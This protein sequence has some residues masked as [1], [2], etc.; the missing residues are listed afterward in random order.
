MTKTIDLYKQ[1]Y[2]YP[3]TMFEPF[4]YRVGMFLSTRVKE[5]PDE[6]F[7]LGCYLAMQQRFGNVAIDTNRLIG[8]SFHQWPGMSVDLALLKT[9]PLLQVEITSVHIGAFISAGVLRQ[10][11]KVAI[12][13]E[14][15]SIIDDTPLVLY[16]EWIY[17]LRYWR[18]ETDIVDYFKR[19]MIFRPVIS[20]I[21][22]EQIDILS[23]DTVDWQQLAVRKA[24]SYPVTIITGG[25]GT[26]KTYTI[27]SVL[28]VLLKNQPFTK[29]ALCAPTGK[30]ASRMM[31]SIENSLSV[32][33]D[34]I[35][36][37]PKE[38]ITIHRL[39][40]WNP[41][42]GKPKYHAG[43]KLPYD[44]VILDEASM[45]D[46]ALLSRLVVAIPEQ[47]RLILLGDKDQ[48]ASVEAGS[49]FGEIASIDQESVDD[50]EFKTEQLRYEDIF[51]RL[52]VSRR[53]SSESGIGLLAEMVNRSDADSSWTWLKEQNS[54]TDCH[55]GNSDTWMRELTSKV[56]KMHDR[57]IGEIADLQEILSLDTPLTQEMG[58]K[59]NALFKTLTESQILS[60]HRRGV[61]GS[62][63]F[64]KIIDAILS[65]KRGLKG[66]YPKNK[67]EGWYH[68]RPVIVTANDYELGL[69][70]G[71]VGLAIVI[72]DQIKITFGYDAITNTIR[73]YSPAQLTNVDTSWIL[74]V[75]KSQGSE[76]DNVDLILPD[77][78]SPILTRELA[79]TALTRSK[80]SF[81][82]WGTEKVWKEMINC[83]IER[84]SGLGKRLSARQ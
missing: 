63:H 67:V 50:I 66:H 62:I 34:V 57:L 8:K 4:D 44:I 43:N 27:L 75:H 24:L 41:S 53:F 69:F 29:I 10:S 20:Q 51:V 80:N 17:L 46:L 79:Y 40:G 60:A 65:E 72:H 84:K 1:I 30:A 52:R 11:D 5:Y 6:A 37:I 39:I 7:L 78:I 21:D 12:K 32:V 14:F 56:S 36:L 49:V 81:T 83:K 15:T 28:S 2:G 26:G 16:D 71:D 31:E 54:I 82:L 76:F 3:N 61:F 77:E 70:N 13:S 38:A 58:A 47:G 9:I 25:P 55:I 19:N 23:N 18:Y 74:T 35:P 22:I 59:I 68:G 33:E 73:W 64:N 48:L 42:S 45:V